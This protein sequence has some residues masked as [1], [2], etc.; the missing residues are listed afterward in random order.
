[1]GRW[2]PR[3]I[4]TSGHS[5]NSKA[6]TSSD[7]MVAANQSRSITPLR[8]KLTSVHVVESVDWPAMLQDTVWS[9]G[10][11]PGSGTHRDT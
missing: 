2:E 10:A 1:M 3:V 11:G 9:G 6:T 8:C 5:N 7:G 4:Q